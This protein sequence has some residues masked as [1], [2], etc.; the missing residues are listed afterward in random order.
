MEHETTSPLFCPLC[1]AANSIDINILFSL[2]W[3][4]I[5]IFSYERDISGCYSCLARAEQDI[6]K[7]L[8][9]TQPPEFN[10]QLCSFR[11]RT[12]HKLERNIRAG[13]AKAST[14]K[15]SLPVVE[16]RMSRPI[17]NSY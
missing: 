16:V 10:T 4:W 17:L 1:I 13:H 15:V 9:A 11:P 3:R 2:C 5:Q 8:R 6:G 7:P 12:S 14:P